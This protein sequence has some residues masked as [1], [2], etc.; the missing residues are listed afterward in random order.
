MQSYLMYFIIIVE[1]DK[2][3]M[4][5][6]MSIDLLGLFYILKGVINNV[7]NHLLFLRYGQLLGSR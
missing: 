1:F 2:G 4:Q 5:L 7:L 3:N 6:I